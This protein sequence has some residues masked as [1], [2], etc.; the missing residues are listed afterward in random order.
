MEEQL[1][2]LTAALKEQFP[3]HCFIKIQGE[4]T[5]PLLVPSCK[6]STFPRLRKT[7]SGTKVT[8]SGEN[9]VHLPAAEVD[10]CSS[11][12]EAQLLAEA[13]NAG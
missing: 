3:R 13:G 4:K 7:P 8:R 5:Q 2:E 11:W 1:T 12:Q 9:T 6:V 10:R